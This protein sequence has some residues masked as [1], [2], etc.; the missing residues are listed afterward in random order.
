VGQAVEQCRCHFGVAEHSCPFAEAEV[1]GD[2]DAGALVEL[3]PTLGSAPPRMPT[4]D[5]APTQPGSKAEAGG[6]AT[7]PPLGNAPLPEAAPPPSPAAPRND[8]ATDPR[9]E[10]GHREK[11]SALT[12]FIECGRQTL[13]ELW[14]L[15][16]ELVSLAGGGI[17][18]AW[19]S[20]GP[21]WWT[22]DDAD[23]KF[24][25]Q[26]REI[27]AA[28]EKNAREGMELLAALH[29]YYGDVL[30]S[31]SVFSALTQAILLIYSEEE[32]AA[33]AVRGRERA[34]MLVAEF[35]KFMEEDPDYAVGYL[36]CHI[37]QMLLGGGALLR[38][39]RSI[40][41]G[42]PGGARPDL[43]APDRSETPET[44]IDDPDGNG[45]PTPNGPARQ[46][47]GEVRPEFLPADDPDAVPLG[48]T[49]DNG[50]VRR[51]GLPGSYDGLTPEEMRRRG[52]SNNWT[53][54][55][56]PIPAS[57]PATTDMTRRRVSERSPITGSMASFLII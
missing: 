34:A 50:G 35:R 46:A 1:G 42:I 37:G 26:M 13:I 10:S 52:A 11:G 6:G 40:R 25:Q 30:S 14:E 41:R 23:E 53:G 43:D 55:A 32:W 3:P 27:R 36:V 24:G 8:E 7:P 33:M 12:G 17:A 56:N 47:E 51:H 54:Q 45:A 57:N 5:A 4:S 21:G 39:V 20:W 28:L 38:I 2:D 48:G 15:I 16:K 22:D 49:P 44:I 18:A 29:T 19:E 9:T 31:N